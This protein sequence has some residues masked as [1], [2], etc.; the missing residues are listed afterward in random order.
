LRTIAV[1]EG[2]SLYRHDLPGTCGHSAH[3]S[4][5]A[6][7]RIMC[8][9]SRDRRRAVPEIAPARV[10]AQG[11]SPFGWSVLVNGAAAQIP[12]RVGD[13]LGVIR[14]ANQSACLAAMGPRMAVMRT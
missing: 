11:H 4:I 6:R 13:A 7:L 2:I 10:N 8:F 9:G 1:V 12:G 3:T 5:S 14:M